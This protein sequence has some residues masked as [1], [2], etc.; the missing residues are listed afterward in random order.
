MWS[1]FEEF[2]HTRWFALSWTCSQWNVAVP[3]SD[4]FSRFFQTDQSEESS[5]HSYG[6]KTIPMSIV[7]EEILV[8]LQSSFTSTNASSRCSVGFLFL[9]F[10]FDGDR[11]RRRYDRYRFDLML[12]F[13]IHRPRTVLYLYRVAFSNKIKTDAHGSWFNLFNVWRKEDNV[14]AC[15]HFKWCCSI[16]RISPLEND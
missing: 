5:A 9:L 4:L 14:K 16:K 8:T 12:F 1:M 10:E 13:L 2:L 7:S 3:M 11:R 6:W 15:F